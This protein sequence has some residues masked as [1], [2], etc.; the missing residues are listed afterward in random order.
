MTSKQFK[1]MRELLE[2]AIHLSPSVDFDRRA[3]DFLQAVG[4]SLNE[5]EDWPVAEPVPVVIRDVV[6][7]VK[8]IFGPREF[9]GGPA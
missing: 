4:S 6:G 7:E 9:R 5:W 8:P 3:N 2:E 1:Q